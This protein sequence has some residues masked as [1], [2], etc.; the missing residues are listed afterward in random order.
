Q[1]LDPHLT[2]I[3]AP[4]TLGGETGGQAVN[5][6]SAERSYSLQIA[7]NQVI[8]SGGRVPGQISSASFQRDSSY[9]AFRNAIDQVVATVRQQFISCFWIGHLS[10]YRRNQSVCFRANC[11]INRTD[12]RRAR[13]PD[14]TCCRL[15]SRSQTSSRSSLRRGTTIPFLNCNSLRPWGSTLIR[16]VGI[17]RHSR[18]LGN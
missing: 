15:K 10:V 1:D 6:V 2:H 14:S 16:A 9:Y 4:S 12:S 13:S 17:A 5:L 7:A 18:L 11:K 8:F 3:S